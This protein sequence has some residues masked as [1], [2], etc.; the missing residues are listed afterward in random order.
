MTA[1]LDSIATGTEAGDKSF[2][3]DANG[4]RKVLENCPEA[5]YRVSLIVFWGRYQLFLYLRFGK[6]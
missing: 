2:T 1:L 6:Y 5:C 3:Y 4:S